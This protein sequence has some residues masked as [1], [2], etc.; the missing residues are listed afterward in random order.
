[1]SYLP[2]RYD[3]GSVDFDMNRSLLEL[4]IDTIE[5]FSSIFSEAEGSKTDPDSQPRCKVGGWLHM[6]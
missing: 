3:K 5:A 4:I 1:M 6:Y 2:L